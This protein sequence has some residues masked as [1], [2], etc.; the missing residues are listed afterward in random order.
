[1]YASFRSQHE[2]RKLK[3]VWLLNFCS[4]TL[5]VVMLCYW[6]RWPEHLYNTTTK[7]EDSTI[8]SGSDRSL[9]Q[10]VNTSPETKYTRMRK[11]RWPCYHLQ[12]FNDHSIFCSLNGIVPTLSVGVGVS[13]VVNIPT[14]F[15]HGKYVTFQPTWPFSVPYYVPDRTDHEPSVRYRTSLDTCWSHHHSHNFDWG[16]VPTF[17]DWFPLPYL[18]Y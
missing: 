15:L 16:C 11:Y 14:G 13:N 2:H 10:K 4:N 17:I 1:M 18:K 5:I 7:P 6:N 9:G 12:P 8:K 3:W